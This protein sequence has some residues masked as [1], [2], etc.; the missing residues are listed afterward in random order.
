MEFNKLRLLLFG[1]NDKKR[2]SRLWH[3]CNQSQHS[4]TLLNFD[5]QKKL[6]VCPSKFTCGPEAPGDQATDFCVDALTASLGC[7]ERSLVERLRVVSY[8]C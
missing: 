3:C 8:L 7:L 4:G 5:E 2:A 1:N 6:A